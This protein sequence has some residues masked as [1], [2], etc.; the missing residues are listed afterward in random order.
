MEIEIIYIGLEPC[1]TEY[2]W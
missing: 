2:T 1:K